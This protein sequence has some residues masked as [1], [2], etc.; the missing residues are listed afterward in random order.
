MGE[1]GSELLTDLLRQVSRSFYLTM[2]VLPSAIRRQ[3]GLAYLL[4]RTTDTIADT[5]L[6]PLDKRLEA[7]RWL[8]ERISGDTGAPFDLDE[9]VGYQ[10]STA[11]RSLLERIEEALDLLSRLP[12]DDQQH[13]REVLSII[14]SGQELDL[15]RFANAS[16]DRV[17]SLNTDQELDD[18]TYRVAGCVGEFWTKICRAHIFADAAWDDAFLLDAAVRFG[19]GL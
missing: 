14:T 2:R 1:P 9:L 16:V 17:V 11:E 6:L 8:R 19:K 13:V 4:A 7:L 18:Y 3:I 10:G 15:T 5:Q 12:S